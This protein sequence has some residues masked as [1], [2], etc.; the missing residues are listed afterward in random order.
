MGAPSP[1]ANTALSEGDSSRLIRHHVLT[2]TLIALVPFGWLAY[3]FNW[4]VD[5]AFISF[6]YA[7]HLAEG[8]GLCFNVG[9]NPRVEGYSNFLWIL[10]LAPFEMMGSCL[11]YTSP[12]PRDS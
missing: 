6:R 12:S 11:L 4:V 7:R 2:V 1:T 5:D 10:V 9:E 8:H 3:Q